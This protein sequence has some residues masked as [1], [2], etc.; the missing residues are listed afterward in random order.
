MEEW[1][2]ILKRNAPGEKGIRLLV[3]GATVLLFLVV[4]IDAL[5]ARG[6]AMDGQRVTLL[7]DDGAATVPSVYRVPRDLASEAV[8][9]RQLAEAGDPAADEIEIAMEAGTEE[10][11]EDVA[12]ADTAE[13]TVSE[14]ADAEAPLDEVETAE[15]ELTAD[16]AT[17]AEMAEA[18]T[19]EQT[20]AP[21]V[22]DAAPADTADAESEADVAQTEP[23]AAAED[24]TETAEAADAVE[25]APDAGEDAGLA[26]LA[27]AD[28]ENGQRVWRQCAACHV[29]DAEQNRGGPHLVGIIGRDI[30]AAEGWRYSRALSEHG[31]EWSVDALLAWLEN[32]DSYIPGNQMAFRGLRNEQDRIDVLGFLNASS[33]N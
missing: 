13:D 22:A 1:V 29:H 3:A 30:G 25:S 24:T 7:R 17:E 31:G 4:I 9:E 19:A 8:R 26:L 27:G 23:E 28:V 15:S 16:D 2:K 10:V 33:G 32:P 12:E 14:M 5:G 18:D 11:A 20:E 21:E 6:R